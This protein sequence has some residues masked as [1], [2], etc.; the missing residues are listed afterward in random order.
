MVAQKK[1]AVLA[2]GD[3]Q[4]EY[5][6]FSQIKHAV[7]SLKIEQIE[8]FYI[9]QYENL[10]L[11]KL[12]FFKVIIIYADRWQSI[13]SEKFTDALMSYVS[14]GGNVMIVHNGICIAN[15]E[16][17]LRLAGTKFKGHP[18]MSKLIYRVKDTQHPIMQGIQDFVLQEEP[19][20]FEYPTQEACKL[21]LSYEYE[22]KEYPAAWWRKYDLGK[23]VYLSP[24]HD[25][26]SLEHPVYKQMMTNTINWL[27]H[28]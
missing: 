24:G 11:E 18:A 19:Y 22:G 7:Q 15:Q 13:V 23:V 10:I 2:I 1:Y 28:I 8:L 17:L 27:L 20:Q 21:I 14:G 6:P 25:K 16:K 5:H 4:A 26:S 12:N 9:A 3:E